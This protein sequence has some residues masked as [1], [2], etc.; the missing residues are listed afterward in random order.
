MILDVLVCK[1][2][3]NWSELGKYTGK[4]YKKP[5]THQEI[6]RSP[7]LLFDPIYIKIFR[8]NLDGNFIGDQGFVQ[9]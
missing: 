9:V 3:E 7:V 2:G 5:P 6:E 1:L 8:W 4:D